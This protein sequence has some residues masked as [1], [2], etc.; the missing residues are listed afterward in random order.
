MFSEWFGEPQPDWPRQVRLAGFP[1]TDGPADDGLSGDTIEFCR[2]GSPPIAFTFGSGMMHAT[3]RFHDAIEACRILGTRG[4]LLTKFPSQLT[5][6]MPTFMHHCAYAPFQK[7]FPLCAAVVHHG[8]I[9]TTAKALAAGVP[10]L[11]VPFAY[12]QKDNAI[13]VKRLGAGNWVHPRKRSAEAIAGA[14]QRC[15]QAEP[16]A[17]AQTI[18]A[19]FRDRTGTGSAADL[20]DEFVGRKRSRI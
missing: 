20:V 12:D 16:T 4:I 19:R 7:L 10:Q 1:S 9:G 2:A 11:I 8:G 14:L 18:A 13:R 17:H 5:K 3:G 6:A 15:I